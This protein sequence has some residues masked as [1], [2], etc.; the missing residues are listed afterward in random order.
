M[1]RSS[2]ASF[3]AEMVQ[4]F[5][6]EDAY[7]FGLNVV[8]KGALERD[9]PVRMGIT[10]G[11]A[12]IVGRAPF[13]FHETGELLGREIGN[14]HRRPPLGLVFLGDLLG[15]FTGRILDSTP[16]LDVLNEATRD[17]AFEFPDPRRFG[18]AHTT[19]EVPMVPRLLTL[20]F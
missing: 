9:M 20:A 13:L 10:D 12:G 11:H 1:R 7:V 18:D 8:A 16:C 15:G 2:G 6:V 19:S 3:C 14:F 5:A 4:G 17:A